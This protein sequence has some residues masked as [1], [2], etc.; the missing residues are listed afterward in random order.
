MKI[1]MKRGKRD[2]PDGK[3][4]VVWWWQVL[5]EQDGERVPD[6]VGWEYE[7]PAAYESAVRFMRAERARREVA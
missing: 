4:Q 5:E 7:K 1:E 6:G 2:G 3:P